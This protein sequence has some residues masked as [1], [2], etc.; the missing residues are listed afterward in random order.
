[1]SYVEHVPRTDGAY[2]FVPKRLVR[3]DFLFKIFDIFD[4]FF[5]GG[6]HDL[7]IIARELVVV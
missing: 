1:M 2:Y 6:F 4:H 3:L 5:V 7:G